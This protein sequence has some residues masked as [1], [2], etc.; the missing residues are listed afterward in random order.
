MT[1]MLTGR[2]AHVGYDCEE[3]AKTLGRFAQRARGEVG[4]ARQGA[5]EGR[6]AL[7]AGQ[8][9][10]EAVEAAKAAAQVVDHVD[11]RGL[12]RA[13]DDRAAVLELAVVAEDDVQEA[14]GPVGREAGDLL[15]LAADRVVPQRYLALELAEV[16]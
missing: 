6:P 2:G 13:R 14:L 4:R 10:L 5:V 11:Q 1:R 12:A 15:D 9:L 3:S 16:G 8:A 7:A